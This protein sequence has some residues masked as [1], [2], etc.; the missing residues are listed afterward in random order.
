MGT[1]NNPYEMGTLN[2]PFMSVIIICFVC[3]ETCAH[4]ALCWCYSGG[5]GAGADR[6][7]EEEGDEETLVPQKRSQ[8]PEEEFSDEEINYMMQHIMPKVLSRAVLCR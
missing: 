3:V 5:A 2:N 7:E 6:E 1:L 8:T 4:V